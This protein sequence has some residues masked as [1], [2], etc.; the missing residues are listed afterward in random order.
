MDWIKILKACADS[1]SYIFRMENRHEKH[2][3]PK[4]KYKDEK[5]V[6][7]FHKIIG[8]NFP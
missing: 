1:F 2:F 7:F 6:V 3:I 4:R 8:M 5:K